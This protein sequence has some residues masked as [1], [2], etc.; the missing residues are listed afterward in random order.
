MN[1][2]SCAQM[3]AAEQYAIAHGVPALQ[4]MKNAGYAAAE[5]LVRQV[6][7]R[8]A[9]ALVLCG[10]GNN[11]GDGYV[12]ARLLCESGAAVSV[13][14]LCGAPRTPDAQHMAERLRALPGIRWADAAALQNGQ[15]L[16]GYDFIVDAVFGTGFHGELD[17]DTAAL[18]AGINDSGV[19]VFAVDMPSGANADTGLAAAQTLRARATVTFGAAKKGQLLSPARAYCGTLEAVPIGIAPEAF[20]AGVPQL[21]DTA[22]LR[23]TLPV[24]A[25]ESNKGTFGRLLC[26]VGRLRYPG[27]AFMAGMAAAR[28]GAGLVT[29]GT[30]ASAR[31]LLAARLAEVMTLPLPETADGSLSLAALEPILRFARQCSAVLIGCGLTQDGETQALVRALLARLRGCVILDA[32]GINA[33]AGHIDVLRFSK[34]DLVLTPHPGEMARLCGQSI[35]QIQAARGKTAADFARDTG[36]TLVLKGAG[37]LTAAPDGRMW[38]NSTGNPGLAR[39][40]SGDILAGMVAGLAAQ[41][42]APANAAAAAVYLHGLAADRAAARRGQYG[43]L[44]TDLLEEIPQIFC[45]LSR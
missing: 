13:A 12:I 42:I 40:G 21:P 15:T 23:E 44:P 3:K 43:M 29:V 4:L 7:V 25:T 45:E 38:H 19:P 6:R 27:A 31:P 10:A 1:I 20:P 28:C 41:H 8:G 36:V 26:V 32:D 24:R 5:W 9:Q 34:A 14:P 11:G 30:A 39:G 33:C 37:T 17:A 35:A 22:F 18:F 2:I 16:R